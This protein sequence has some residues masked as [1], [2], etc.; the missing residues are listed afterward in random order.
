MIVEKNRKEISQAPMLAI[1]CIT[2]NHEQYIRDALEGFVMQK[3]NFPFVAIVHDDA[4]TDGTTAIIKEYAEKYPDIIR[5]IFETENQYSKKDGSLRRIMNNALIESN[6]KYIALCEGDDYWTDP[7]KLQKQVDFLESHP[8]YTLCFHNALVKYEDRIKEPHLFA[9]V[10]SREY[11]H[12]EFATE[13]FIPTASAVFRGNVI[14]S[15]IYYNVLNKKDINIGDAPLWFT[16]VSLGKAYGFKECMS[17]Y[18]IQPNGISHTIRN[19]SIITRLK[20]YAALSQ[21]YPEPLKSI[22][23]EY[24]GKHSIMMLSAFLRGDI[25]KA[26]SFFQICCKNAPIQSIKHLSKYPYNVIKNKL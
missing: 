13:W 7:Y 15:S 17:V 8:E 1:K 23:K 19:Q 3:T 12:H 4:S 25:R 5:P 9:N 10:K 16:C 11:L 2:Y 14:T 22:F 18:R 6:A 21:V 20:Y 26:I 24:L